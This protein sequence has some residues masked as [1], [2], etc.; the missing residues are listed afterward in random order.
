[1]VN[2]ILILLL[3]SSIALAQ[4]SSSEFKLDYIT[5]LTV[6]TG[7]TV[8]LLRRHVIKSLDREFVPLVSIVIGSGYGYLAT[9]IMSIQNGV[10]LGVMSGLLA[11][12]VTS[13]A[14]QLVNSK[15]NKGNSNSENDEKSW[16]AR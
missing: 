3:F 4:D 2:R 8:S 5:L 12:G 6:V 9:Q 11:S 1:M 13:W 14:K 7:S 15:E 10:E 16:W